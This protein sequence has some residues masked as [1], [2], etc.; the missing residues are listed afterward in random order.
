MSAA[1]V[2]RIQIYNVYF[3]YIKAS[4]ENLRDLSQSTNKR[5]R[6]TKFTLNISKRVQAI[7]EVSLKDKNLYKPN[8]ERV[9]SH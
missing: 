3:E 6:Y 4:A 9:F 1:E 2:G 7:F 5:A 8:N